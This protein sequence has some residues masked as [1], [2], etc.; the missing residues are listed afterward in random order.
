MSAFFQPS[1]WF[2]MQAPDVGGLIGN[3][4]FVF[5]ILVLILGI[6]GRIVVDRK[7]SDQYKRE[8]GSRIS[9][10]LVT[11]GI[12]GATLF[13]FSFE[14]IQLFGARFWYPVWVIVTIFWGCLIVRFIKRDIPHMKAR[15]QV[16]QHQRT[17]LPGPRK[18]RRR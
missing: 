9:S 17:Y 11:M 8:I 6:V 3:L 18:K 2:T 13:F 5:F 7:T 12:L 4:V 10:L 15:A 1:Y 14:R 16:H